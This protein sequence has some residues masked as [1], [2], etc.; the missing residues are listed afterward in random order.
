M[1]E[2]PPLD[3]Q[4]TQLRQKLLKRLGIAG[5]M[6]LVLL[7]V[8]AF[9]DYL[10]TR[11]E[12]PPAK[13]FTKPV[14]V[15]PKKEVTQPLSSSTSSTN[16]LTESTSTTLAPPEAP[17]KG[18]AP[19]NASTTAAIKPAATQ[20]PPTPAK[21]SVQPASGTAR[22]QPTVPEAS[23]APSIESPRPTSPIRSEA[24]T[25]SPRAVPVPPTAPAGS[26]LARLLS[27]YAVQAGVF[28][29]ARAA[30]ELHAKLALNGIPSTLEARVQIGPF[31]TKA[32]A[33]AAK[34]KLKELGIEGLL[35]PPSG[36]R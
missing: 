26:G 4:E 22:T 16:L 14:P 13:V 12:E 18:E 23:A 30:E 7:G 36:R 6:A 25:A 31:K 3:E 32:E 27:G 17:A 2:L 21:P 24:A 1:A 19:T 35:I 28:T 29:N 15:P 34:K 20:T 9:F 11:R 33:E 8:L 10:A 5:A